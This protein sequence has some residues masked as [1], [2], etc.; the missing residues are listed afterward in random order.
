[1]NRVARIKRLRGILADIEA[2][3]AAC[4]HIGTWFCNSECR[5]PGL[6]EIT[7]RMIEKEGG[8]V[9]RKDERT[10]RKAI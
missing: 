4:C 10:T 6:K 8:Y 2:A 7:I 9:E 1:M 5:R 3:C